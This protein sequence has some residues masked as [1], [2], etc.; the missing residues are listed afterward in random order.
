[1]RLRF[2]SRRLVHERMLLSCAGCVITGRVP[3]A[4]SYP[5]FA[6]V[7]IDIGRYIHLTEACDYAT[8]TPGWRR[9][10]R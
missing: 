10:R 3:F 2:S 1:M 8:T 7:R 4:L 5:R 9:L 6:E